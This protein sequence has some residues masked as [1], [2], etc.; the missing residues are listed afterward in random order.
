VDGL[1]LDGELDTTLSWN[2]LDAA[3]LY[4]IEGST[5]SELSVHG[6]ATAACT[7]ASVAGTSYLS[8]QAE[9]EPGD[10]YY[11]L[12]R[13]DNACGTGSYGTDSAGAERTRAPL[14]P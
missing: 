7:T 14:C 8:S 6:T 11:Y 2:G 3:D 1:A 9:P 4:D 5:L 12:V 10:G 13:A